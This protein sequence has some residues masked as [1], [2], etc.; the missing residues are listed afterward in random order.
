MKIGLRPRRNGAPHPALLGPL[1][2][3]VIGS[4]IRNDQL[5]AGPTRADWRNNRLETRVPSVPRACTQI[6]S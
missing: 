3:K 1:R 2:L 6:T 5:L 4:R